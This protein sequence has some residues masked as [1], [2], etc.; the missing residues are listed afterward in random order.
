MLSIVLSTALMVTLTVPA[1]A[2]PP[3]PA[4]PSE[5]PALDLSPRPLAFETQLPLPSRVVY[6]PGVLPMIGF[7]PID[8]PPFDP[9]IAASTLWRTGWGRALYPH[10]L[11]QPFPGLD[12]TP[13][14]MAG[15]GLQ[16][17][18]NPHSSFQVPDREAT[19]RPPEQPL[20]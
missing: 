5:A 19:Q 20:K 9:H 7:E 8:T 15:Q 14:N 1:L 6:A 3:E 17:I 4:A 16:A 12:E 13:L 2:A 10:V 18:P 11:D